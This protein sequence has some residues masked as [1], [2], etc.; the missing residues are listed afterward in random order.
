MSNE[1]SARALEAN[2][3]RVF[4]NLESGLGAKTGLYG[5]L[6]EGFW[7]ALGGNISEN[8]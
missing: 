3:V 2:Y 5:R 1:I 7:T 8:H 4:S 6:L